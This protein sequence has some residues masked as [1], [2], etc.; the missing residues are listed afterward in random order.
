[1]ARTKKATK[2]TA[3]KRSKSTPQRTRKSTSKKSNGAKQPGDCQGIAPRRLQRGERAL[4]LRKQGL[5]WV[6]IGRKMKVSGSYARNC[7]ADIVGGTENL[8]PIGD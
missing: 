2:S 8:P 7:A 6:E 4:K 1:M 3:A 5:S